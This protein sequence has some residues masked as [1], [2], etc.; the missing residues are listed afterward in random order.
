MNSLDKLKKSMDFSNSTKGL[1]DLHSA[2]GRFNLGPISTQV[3][4]V[5]AKF[6]AMATIGVTALSN[7]ANQALATGATFVKAMTL[8]P[9]KMG[10]QEYETNLNSIQTILAN[11]EASGATLKDVTGALDELNEYSDKTIYN[12][13]EMARNIGTFTAAG[14]DLDA[15]TAAIKGIANLAAMSGSNSQQASTAMYQLSQA[16]AAGR[17]TLMDWNSV[18]NAGMGG[19]VFQR[20]LAETAVKMGKLSDKSVSLTGDMKNV[21]I[22]GESFRQSI[23]QGPNAG[24]LT[25]DVLTK[26]LAQFTGDLTDAELAAQGF[27]KAEIKAIQAQ[28]KTAQEAATKVKTLTQTLDVAKETAQSGWSQ[29]WRYIFGDFNE[30]RDTFT[31][32]SNTINGF[33]NANA[34]AR[35]KIAKDWKFW[36]GR[37]AAIDAIKYAFEALISIVE[38]IKK[39]FQQFFPAKTGQ[40]LADITKNIRDFFKGLKL[41]EETADKVQRIFAGFFAILDIGATIVKS[42]FG[43]FKQLFSAVSDGNGDWLE[44]AARIGDFLVSLNETI[45]KSGVITGF[46]ENLGK[47]MSVPIRLFQALAAAILSVFDGDNQAI[48]SASD[49]MGEFVSNMNPLERVI[50]AVVTGWNVFFSAIK[51]TLPFFSSLVEGI[52]DLFGGI[53]EAISGSVENGN[54]QAVLD[55]INTVLLGGIALMIKKFVTNGFKV[56][57][58]GGM[59][60]SLGESFNALTGYLKAM[61]QQVKAKTLLMIA[62]AVALLAASVLVLASI[63][64]KKLAVA[65]SG[66]AAIFTQLF[67]AMGI[68]AKMANSAGFIKIPL[69]AGSLILLASAILIMSFALKILSTLDWEEIGKGL[70]ALAGIL[71]MLVI[72]TQP[73]AA[74]SA[75]LIA[76][77]AALILLGIGL[78]IMAGALALLGTLEW[79]TIGRGLVAIVGLLTAIAIPLQLMSGPKMVAQGAALIMI[80]GAISILAGAL[81]ILGTMSWEEIA[82]GLTAVLGVLAAIAISMAVMPG[83]MMI[84]AAAGLI[85]VG[86]AL[87]IIAGAMK[88]MGTM[89]W[90]EIGKGLVTLGGALLLLAGGLYLM[91]GALPGAAA[92]LVAAAALAIITPVLVTL[93]KLSWEEIARGLIALA[94]AFAVI[95]LA[96]LLL[97]PIIGQILLLS[98]AI[99]LLGLGFALIGVGVLAFAAGI[100]MLVAAASAGTLAMTAILSTIIGLIPSIFKVVE[101]AL[102]ALA[103]AVINAAPALFEATVVLLTGMLDAIEE[104]IPDILDTLG[105][106]LDAALEFILEYAPKLYA[107]GF[108]LL[109]GFLKAIRDNLPEV[110]DVAGDIV[111]E[112]IE[113]IGAKGLEIAEAAA[114]TLITFI[115]G[116]S[117]AIDKKAP[118]LDAAVSKLVTAIVDGLKRFVAGRLSD[119]GNL[120]AEIGNSILNA[121]KSALGIAS[122]SKE[123]VKVGKAINDGLIKGVV[124]GKDKVVATLQYIRDELKNLVQS[125]KDDLKDARENL[126]RLRASGASDKEI[127]KAEKA[128]AKAE[129]AHKAALKANKKFTESMKKQKEQLK[130]LGKQYDQTVEK[131]DAAYDAL[132][133]ATQKRDDFREAT[134]DAF[135][136][137]PDIADLKALRQ[138]LE[139]LKGALEPDPEAIA[140]AQK[141]YDDALSLDNYFDSI[142]EAKDE[143]DAFLA[144]LTKLREF[145]LSDLNY[146]KFISEGTSIMPFLDEL[147]AAG[148]DAVAELNTIAG[149]L[150]SSAAIIGKTTSDAMYQAGVDSAQ[151]IVDGLESKL[152]QITDEMEELGKAMAEALKKALNIKSPSKV[153]KKIGDQT[154]MGLA[155][156]IQAGAKVVDLAAVRLGKGAADALR[157]SMGNIQ[158][159]IDANMDIQ[160]TIAPV[161]DLDA[162]RKEAQRMQDILATTPVQANVSLGMA[163]DI[164]A[165]EDAF[166]KAV[167]DTLVFDYT[168]NNYSPKAISEAELYRQTRNQLSTV[169]GVISNA[170]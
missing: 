58:G 103:E 13:S 169:K 28:A 138:E 50:N 41:G 12:F 56:D 43:Y 34:D 42:A 83:P 88:I 162:F 152:D 94:G 54:Y 96:A 140:R 77:S 148:P 17:I 73:L 124:G 92:L 131:L 116:L 23:S 161:L 150:D 60:D 53:G 30:A 69:I 36:G 151:G 65:L 18:V 80:A 10:L 4:R 153:M 108:E 5:N 87:N 132:E 81:K 31:D 159:G 101:L 166:Q 27:N 122:P 127:A 37:T 111:I 25:S 70:T 157:E 40:Q 49:A 76:A 38:P 55:T 134:K 119:I 144:Q 22:A 139:E 133:E 118:Q 136:D 164:Q 102:I 137:L 147:I 64:P 143:N 82:K 165:K 89:S 109:I 95:G 120:G 115:N 3:E 117:D 44:I 125:T 74:N 26:T 67:V 45:K 104:I 168:Q 20:A 79:E 160:P 114:D 47:V 46:F 32:L 91:T 72:T 167:G 163:T 6:L 146:E 98:G 57:L 149:E 2:A 128:L 52:A 97:T 1:N 51:K 78:T 61:E 19:T 29:T 123:F 145:G 130:A 15:S 135:D 100:T 90:E 68:L 11:T 106:L 16:M 170:N 154:A 129:K 48:N 75:K 86:I 35:N 141:A 8:D 107:A 142:R 9:I 93:G 66:L 59:L 84:A 112:L 21:S 39:A 105:V 7:I 121:A 99:A 113:G 33:I 63:D 156:G 71:A 155:V 110:I 62:G 126:K 158:A 24:W 85:L 14:V